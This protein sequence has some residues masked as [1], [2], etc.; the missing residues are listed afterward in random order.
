MRRRHVGGVSYV[1]APAVLAGVARHPPAGFV[2]LDRGFRG[3]QLE[4]LVHKRVRD[5]IIF[6]VVLDVVIDVDGD[7]FPFGQLVTLGGQRLQRWAFQLLEQFPAGGGLA[8]EGPP[9][10]LGHLL[11][12]GPVQIGQAEELQL[13]QRRQHPT[14]YDQDTGFDGCFIAGPVGPCRQYYRAVMVGQLGIRPVY[15]RVVITGFGDARFQVVGRRS[16]R[17]AAVRLEGVHVGHEPARQRLVR[18]GLDV[19]HPRGPEHG[20]EDLGLGDLS[21]RGVGDRHLVAAEVDEGPLAGGVAEAHDYFLGPEPAVVVRAE[22]AVAPTVWVL[23]LPFEPDQPQG[24]VL[25]AAQLPVHLPPVRHPRGR[26]PALYF[27]PS[28]AAGSR[29][30]GCAAPCAPPAS[31]APAGPARPWAVGTDAPPAPLRPSPREVARTARLSQL[32]PGT[33]AP[34]RALPRCWQRPPSW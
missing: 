8:P 5:G 24:H 34:W 13:A 1:A 11:P 33:R 26:W 3:P 4:L 31:P 30:C 7:L 20:H 19:E 22:L 29:A 14:F 23:G 15:L 18:G 32:S 16:H 6:V 28:P 9:V 27:R 2:D 21:C 17:H 10:E 25:A 12:D